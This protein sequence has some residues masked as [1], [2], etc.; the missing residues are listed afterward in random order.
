MST[1]LQKKRRNRNYRRRE[2]CRNRQRSQT[3]RT[4]TPPTPQTLEALLPRAPLPVRQT[5]AMVPRLLRQ[6]GSEALPGALYGALLMVGG[7]LM[8]KPLE[9]MALATLTFLL[10]L[11][12]ARPR[13]LTQ[14]HGG[15]W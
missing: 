2:R 14:V 8:D 3:S 9:G 6:Q 13:A 7:G 11:Y 4:S 15:T 10:A 5:A 1:N 12:V